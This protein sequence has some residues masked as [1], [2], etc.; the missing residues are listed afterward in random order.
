MSM[1]LVTTRDKHLRRWVHE[2]HHRYFNGFSDPQTVAE[3]FDA[4]LSTEVGKAAP[5]IDVP[6]LMIAGEVDRIAPLRGQQATVGLFP[7]AR[8][9][10]LP[11]VGHLVHYEAAQGAADAIRTFVDAL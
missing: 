8:L 4:S 2:E 9:V 11:G 3:A 5:R 1:S 6:V 7:D 10:V